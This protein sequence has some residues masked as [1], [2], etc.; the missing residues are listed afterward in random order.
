MLKVGLR[1]QLTVIPEIISFL[2]TLEIQKMMYGFGDSKFPDK[3][4]VELVE[5]IVKQQMQLLIDLV[6]E[7]ASQQDAKKI[8]IKQFL[9]LLR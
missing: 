6:T 5:K 9:F 4:T 3:E 1:S 8:D 2:C 7:L